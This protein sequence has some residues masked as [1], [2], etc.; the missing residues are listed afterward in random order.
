MG[1][2]IKSTDCASIDGSAE[3]FLPL[4]HFSFWEE[5]LVNA[6]FLADTV[7]WL[8]FVKLKENRETHAGKEGKKRICEKVIQLKGSTKART[9]HAF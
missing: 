9:K 8:F 5:E 3:P 6:I 2:K 7:Q 4:Q 1:I